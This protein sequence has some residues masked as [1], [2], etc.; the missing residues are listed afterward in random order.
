MEELSEADLGEIDVDAEYYKRL[1]LDLVSDDP[2]GG[3]PV[4]PPGGFEHISANWYRKVT[5]PSAL[6]SPDLFFPS[7]SSPPS[8]L[9]PR[10]EMQF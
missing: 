10:K 4:A 6:N 7:F 5:K 3:E 1:Q 2:F 8:L 9:L